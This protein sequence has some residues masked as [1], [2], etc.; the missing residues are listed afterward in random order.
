MTISTTVNRASYA[1]DD[2]STEFSFPYRFLANADLTVILVTDS[3]G[4]EVEQT[5]DTDYTVSGAGDAAGGTVTMTTAPATGETLV[6]IN[7]PDITQATDLTETGILPAESIEAMTD[8]LSIIAQRHASLLTRSIRLPDGFTATFDPTL[9]ASLPA[10]TYIQVNSDGDAFQATEGV[11]A[12]DPLSVPVANGMLAKTGSG[13]R[14][15]RTITGESGVLSV[16]DGDG[17]AGDPTLTIDTGGIGTTKL[18]DGAVTPLK[19]AAALKALNGPGFVNLA[20][21]PDTTSETNDSVTLCSAGGTDLSATNVGYAIARNASNPGILDV[22][23]VTANITLELTKAHWGFGTNGDLTGEP[24][25]YLLINDGGTIRLGAS[26]TA[27]IDEVDVADAEATATN[28]TSAEKVLVDTALSGTSQCVVIGYG[29][30]TFDDTGGAAEDLWAVSSLKIGKK[31]RKWQRNQLASSLTADTDPISDLAIDNLI[32][33]QNYTLS[34]HASF[35]ISDDTARVT[36]TH[37]SA[38]LD[39][40]HAGI[41]AAAANDRFIG[42]TDK[43]FSAEAGSISFAFNEYNTATFEN[44]SDS[45]TGIKEE[46]EGEPIE[47]SSY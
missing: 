34:M 26:S 17:V 47:V 19:A 32:T 30:H 43:Q 18:A 41:P 10:N 22:V 28:V 15:A 6:I 13:T 20:I 44:N 39:R 25:A 35:L 21:K 42:G 38:T 29:L 45:W 40:L 8:K 14:A 31:Y 5:L 7:D 36:A 16:A 1:G 23:D 33:G 27:Q 24:L 11:D 2:S 3:D 9:P 12:T 4:S 46:G 37:N